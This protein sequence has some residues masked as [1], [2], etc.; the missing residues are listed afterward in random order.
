M[1]PE[2]L[3]WHDDGDGVYA[4]DITDP[5]QHSRA[6]TG[7]KWGALAKV[8]PGPHRAGTKM[9]CRHRGGREVLRVDLTASGIDGRLTSATN[10]A[11]VTALFEAEGMNY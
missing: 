9:L 1:H 3:I 10:Q 7:P 4:M 5:R 2:C 11:L 8:R 6:N